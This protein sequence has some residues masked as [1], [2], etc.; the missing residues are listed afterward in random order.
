MI[1]FSCGVSRRA[2]SR[3]KPSKGIINS[4]FN[5]VQSMHTHVVSSGNR[6]VWRRFAVCLRGWQYS[7]WWHINAGITAQQ[8]RD[9]SPLL[10]PANEPS[11]IL[12]HVNNISRL[13]QE[14]KKQPLTPYTLKISWKDR[15]SNF[16]VFISKE[17]I[18]SMY[19]GCVWAFISPQAAH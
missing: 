19:V 15:N 1:R 14:E 16:P 2:G 6:R 7:W 17:S 18:F 13:L 11:R 10:R 4:G 12:H 3:E 5:Y 8:S 9:Q